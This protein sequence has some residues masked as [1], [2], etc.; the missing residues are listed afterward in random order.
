M[1]A[2][3]TRFPA[4][5]NHLVK[6][7]NPETLNLKN[8]AQEMEQTSIHCTFLE[9]GSWL[10]DDV[11]NHGCTMNAYARYTRPHTCSRLSWISQAQA[12]SPENLF[13]QSAA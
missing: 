13:R 7:L 4:P 12:A 9:R 2:Q 1:E 5:V 10:A 6:A 8:C 11:H 3:T